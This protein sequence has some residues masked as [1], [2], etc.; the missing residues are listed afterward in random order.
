MTTNTETPAAEPRAWYINLYELPVLRSE[1]LEQA[2]ARRLTGMA[3][4]MTVRILVDEHNNLVDIE[5][6]EEF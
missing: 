3:K 4:G 5:K 6:V 1:T 2:I